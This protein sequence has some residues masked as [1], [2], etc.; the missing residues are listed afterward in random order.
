MKKKNSQYG[1]MGNSFPKHDL[2]PKAI[3]KT[4]KVERAENHSNF[5]SSFEFR[6][7]FEKK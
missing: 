7:M 3:K 2:K 1:R 6:C 5:L 4:K